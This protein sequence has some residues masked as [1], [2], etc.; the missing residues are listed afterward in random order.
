MRLAWRKLWK[1]Q[2]TLQVS[3]PRGKVKLQ[4]IQIETLQNTYIQGWKK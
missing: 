2:K 4:K 3:F 1:R